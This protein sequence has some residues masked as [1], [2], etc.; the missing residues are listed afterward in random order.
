MGIRAFCPWKFWEQIKKIVGDDLNAERLWPLLLFYNKKSSTNIVQKVTNF[1]GNSPHKRTPSNRIITNK[2]INS[3]ANNNSNPKKCAPPH[4]HTM[5][6]GLF[7]FCV[8]LL[9]MTKSH[10]LFAKF[11]DFVVCLCCGCCCCCRCCDMVRG[12]T[13]GPEP[14]N[15][16][17][18]L[19]HCLDDSE[20]RNDM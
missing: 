14:D 6:N 5:K 15:S 1:G 3:Q 20:Y 7:L 11:I 4:R 9:G 8:L 12:R 19:R 2:Q 16:G 17:G 10:L 18:S 13:K